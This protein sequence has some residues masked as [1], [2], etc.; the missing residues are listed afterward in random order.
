MKTISS[1]LYSHLFERCTTLALCMKITRVDETEYFYTNYGRG[2]VYSDD[3]VE[4]GE[5]DDSGDGLTFT[6]ENVVGGVISGT[7]VV[8]INDSSTTNYVYSF[9]DETDVMS[10]TFPSSQSGKTITADFYYNGDTYLAKG[11]MVPSKLTFS[12]SLSDVSNY[13]VTGY[14]SSAGITKDDFLSRKMDRA[15]VELFVVNYSDITQGK[16]I[17]H[18]GWVAEVTLYD[19][20][21]DMNVEGIESALSIEIGQIISPVCRA[22]LGDNKCKVALNEIEEVSDP[23]VWLYKAEG[24][25][26]ESADNTNQIFLADLTSIL[27]DNKKTDN[28]F[29]YGV[30]RWT[31]GDNAGISIDVKSYSYD[32]GTGHVTIEL[33]HEMMLDI[34]TDDEFVVTAGC[35]KSKTMCQ[36]RFDNYP[37]FQGEPDIPLYKIR[38][39]EI[40]ST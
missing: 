23:F 6:R 13:T 3:Y 24:T 19:Y 18:A 11:S 5:L 14:F 21:F 37:N 35:D 26:L 40:S 32:V 16:M 36:E 39:Y 33:V 8:Y 1:G 34:E 38:E 9:D 2:L 31:S 12:D 7:L 28:F 10:I 20:K 27:D 15:E 29:Q 17:L 4:G 30:L 22:R 25:V